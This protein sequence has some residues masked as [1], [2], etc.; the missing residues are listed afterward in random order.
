[1]EYHVLTLDGGE[2]SG[3]EEFYKTAYGILTKDLD[4]TLAHICDALHDTLYGGVG[5]IQ[6]KRPRYHYVASVPKKRKISGKGTQH[7]LLSYA[8]RRLIGA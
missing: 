8:G 3:L 4:W 2:F 6:T 7:K 5:G 1:M